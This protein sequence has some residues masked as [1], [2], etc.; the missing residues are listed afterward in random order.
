MWLD[1]K[2]INNNNNKNTHKYVLAIAGCKL[3]VLWTRTSLFEP[4]STTKST[5]RGGKHS[6]S[7]KDFPN[8]IKLWDY[9]LQLKLFFSSIVKQS[10]PQRDPN[11]LLFFFFPKPKRNWVSTVWIQLSIVCAY[12]WNMK[13]K[14]NYTSRMTFATVGLQKKPTT[15]WKLKLSNRKKNPG[16]IWGEVFYSKSNVSSVYLDAQVSAS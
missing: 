9:C 16:R 5:Q 6:L 15:V 2:F 4:G 10:N 13:E 14:A 1:L 7:K 3:N 8:A 12:N 11:E